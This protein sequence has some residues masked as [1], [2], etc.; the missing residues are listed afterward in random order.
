MF[1]MTPE[2]NW[3]ST[4][5]FCGGTDLKADQWNPVWAISAYAASNSCVTISPDVDLTWYQDDYLDTGRS[6]GQFINL[7]DGRLLY[8]NGAHLGTA[9][10]GNNTWSIGQS[11]ADQ[12]VQQ[13]WYFDPTQPLGSRWSKAAYSNIPRMYH[14]SASLLVDGSVIVSGSNPNADFIPQGYPGYTYFT[15]YQVEIFYPDY[16]DKPR[17][18]P[19]GMPSTLTYGGDY[20]NVTLTLDDLNNNALNINKTKAVVIRTGFSTHAM[21]MGQRHVEL[22]ASFTS[23]NDGSATL[24]VAQLPPNPAILVPGPALFFIVVDGVPSN[25]S[26]IMVGNGQMGNQP[27]QAASTLP[28][29]TIS[30][31]LLAQSSPTKRS[32][33]S[34]MVFPGVSGLMD[35]DTMKSS[36]QALASG[37]W[38]WGKSW[39]LLWDWQP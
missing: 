39:T 30:A 34:E 4:I 13:A 15:Q 2:N 10:Y 23:N 9:G 18:A 3:T 24:H 14:S 1:P 7:P 21:N 28:I 8:L 37:A 25:S 31:Q 33:P 22:S 20:F 5:I 11:Y 29:S 32:W 16:W 26:W 27:I 19:G 38:R 12:P 36:A 6:M 17:P 35:M